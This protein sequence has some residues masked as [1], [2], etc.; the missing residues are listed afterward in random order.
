MASPSESEL[1]SG[2]TNGKG[3]V[4]ED[5]RL[6][7]DHRPK[8]CYGC[9]LYFPASVSADD[10]KTFF[11][12]GCFAVNTLGRAK[13]PKTEN[14]WGRY[15]IHIGGME[16][17]KIF[18]LTFSVKQ[19]DIEFLPCSVSRGDYRGRL[20]PL[21]LNVRCMDG[22]NTAIVSAEVAKVLRECV[23]SGNLGLYQCVMWYHFPKIVDCPLPLQGR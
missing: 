14:N 10:S 11:C 3:K 6:P 13:I 4:R 1:V 23:R 17:R 21:D 15:L 16:S 22:Y 8:L 5:F 7:A 2:L 9:N 19:C 20:M 12:Q 18:H